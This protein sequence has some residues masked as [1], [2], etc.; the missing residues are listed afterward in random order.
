[1]FLA[2]VLRVLVTPSTGCWVNKN[3]H[4]QVVLC[5]RECLNTVYVAEFL[6]RHTK[7]GVRGGVGRG[8]LRSSRVLTKARIQTSICSWTYIAF[9][10]QSDLHF[11][12]RGTS[13][14]RAHDI[15]TLATYFFTTVHCIV[16][17]ASGSQI[18]LSVNSTWSR[19]ITL[20]KGSPKEVWWITPKHC[21]QVMTSSMRHIKQWFSP[22]ILS[23]ILCFLSGRR[24]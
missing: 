12:L 16:C 10:S 2:T 24:S 14:Q 20:Q 1:M 22:I 19:S 8:R 17:S 6:K 7:G 11:P 23:L 13:V 18:P 15:R 4:S 5:C 3:S 9:F 21:V